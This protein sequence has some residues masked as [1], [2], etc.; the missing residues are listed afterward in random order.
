MSHGEGGICALAP[1]CKQRRHARSAYRIYLSYREGRR[2]LPQVALLE[3][4]EWMYSS[5]AVRTGV[6]PI[7]NTHGPVDCS[8][9]GGAGG[10]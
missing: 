3:A 10:L 8:L 9:A 6:R 5:G 4:D 7:G 2:T 1:P